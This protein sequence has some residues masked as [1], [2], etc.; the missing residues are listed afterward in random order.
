VEIYVMPSGVRQRWHRPD[1]VPNQRGNPVMAVRS[2]LTVDPW[3]DIGQPA[4]V[5]INPRLIITVDRR[6]TFWAYD[7]RECSKR[8]PS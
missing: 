4:G 6:D 5:L 8:L 7:P 3:L 1:E 2:A